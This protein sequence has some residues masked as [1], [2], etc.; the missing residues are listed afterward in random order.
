LLAIFGNESESTW[1]AA[2]AL[3]ILG[4]K[5]AVARL[6]KILS[7]AEDEEKRV[8]AAYSPGLLGDSRSLAPLLNV[9]NDRDLSPKLRSHAAEA[10]G[11]LKDKRAFDILSSE[12]KDASPEVRYSIAFSLGEIGDRR[13]LPE[14]ERLAATDDAAASAG[15]IREM[16]QEAIRSINSVPGD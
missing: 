11:Y 2:K 14:L 6:I 13:A 16:A 1:E 4:S 5:R 10:L 8:T 15:T 7:E 12:I 9:L 3:G